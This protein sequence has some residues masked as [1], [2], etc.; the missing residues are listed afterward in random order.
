MIGGRSVS[1]M[2]EDRIKEAML[3][4]RLGAKVQCLTCERRCLIPEGETGSC[5]T[6]KN[7]NGR[8]YTLEYGDISSLSANPIEKKP[9]FHFYPGTRALTIGSWSCNF[10]CPWCQNYEISKSRD[11][12]GKGQFISPKFFI[13]LVKTHRC[14]GTSVSLNEPTLLFEYSLD[15]FEL[16]KLEGYYN[17]YVTNGYMTSQALDMLVAHGLDAMNIDIKGETEAVKKYCAAN[18][19][20]VWRNAIQAKKLGVWIELATLL[21]PGVNDG[22][23]GLAR[24]ARRI[25]T[26]LGINVPW[27]LTGYYPSYK[28]RNE[29]YVPPTPVSTLEKARMIGRTEGLKYVYVGNV[30][31]HPYENTYCPSC[32]RCLIG[33]YGFSLTRYEIGMDKCCP[34]C[35]EE[36][37]IKCSPLCSKP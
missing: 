5:A 34:Y 17:T 13:K 12:I 24:I 32:N 18:I 6:R 7:T 19:D 21:I 31:G 3:Y 1:G 15:I 23:D 9:F 35:K 37:P 29:T 26:E 4:E 30:P 28:F 11:N 27:H 2:S 16:A 36:I 10:T 22:E 25:K 20:I 8:L 14:Q 33:R